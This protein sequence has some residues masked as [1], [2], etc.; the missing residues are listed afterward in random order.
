MNNY[1]LSHSFIYHMKLKI[2]LTTLVCLGLVAS[3]KAQSDEQDDFWDRTYFG[4]SFSLQF[5][6]Y[7][8]IDISPLMGYRFTD[9]FS[10]GLGATYRYIKDNNFRIESNI[11]GGRIF[12]RYLIT[13]NILAH[14]EY[15]TLN[16]QFYDPNV[17]AIIRDWVPGLLIG[18]GFQ[19]HIGERSGFQILILYNLIYDSLRSPYNEPYVIRVGFTL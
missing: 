4:G 2:F 15:E 6:T 12:S 16:W 19:Q 18:G 1:P 9:R 10:S 3:A 13:E 14:G 11:Y 8:F 17:D 7:T 5:G